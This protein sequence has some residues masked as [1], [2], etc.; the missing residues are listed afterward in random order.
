QSAIRTSVDGVRKVAP[1]HSERILSAQE[2]LVHAIHVAAA[3]GV[4]RISDITGLDR[5]GIPV[6]TA[7]VP[8]SR[9]GI[10]VYNGKGI[11][12]SDSRAGALMEAI[13][14]QTALYAEVP[15]V[16]GSYRDLRN[17]KI[18]ATDPPSFNHKLS[19]DYG[20]ERPYWWIEGYD[21]IAEE[22]V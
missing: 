19:D 5:P 7:V 11:T 21:L 17:G 6:H 16:Q 4:T 14:R 22:P 8:R 9:D 12:P 13:E 2:T 3:K 15:L 1:S 20:E 10:S 18:A